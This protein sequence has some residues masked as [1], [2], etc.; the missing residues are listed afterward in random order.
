MMRKS[1][2]TIVGLAIC[3]LAINTRV[4]AQSATVKTAETDSSANKS[5][6]VKIEGKRQ[7]VAS[8]SVNDGIFRKFGGIASRFSL[9]NANTAQFPVGKCRFGSSYFAPNNFNRNPMRFPTT[10]NVSDDAD[11]ASR[12]DFD[13][14]KERPVT[15]IFTH[16]QTG[17]FWISGQINT[18]VQAHPSFRA[19]YSGDN[20]FTSKS[21]SAV[22]SI[23]TLYT[24]VQLSKRTEFLFHVESLAGKGI[25]NSFGLAG[26]TNLD[27]VYFPTRNAK[28]YVARFML[29]RI[30]PLGKETKEEAR[31]PFSMFA[32]LPVRRLEIRAGKFS[33]ADFFDFNS[34]GTDSYQQFINWTIDNNGAYD[35]AEETRG[36]NYGVMFEYHDKNWGMRFAETLMPKIA[37]DRNLDANLKRAGAENFEVFF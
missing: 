7:L 31:T 37:G 35:Y 20:S 9:A 10:E 6:D 11:V 24:G 3:V 8:Q 12:N 16:N 33:L 29:R 23:L 5:L 13:D 27:V 21:E 15:N 32:E 36:Y 4:T 17:R 30:I 19:K 28:P 34:V 26:F 25:S 18:I 22:F 2:T 14:K 1:L